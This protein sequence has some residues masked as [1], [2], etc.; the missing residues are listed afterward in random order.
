MDL[1]QMRQEILD[2]HEQIKGT[3]DY[4]RKYEALRYI[5]ALTARY[6]ASIYHIDGLY[7]YR[8][9]EK[10]ADNMLL[11]SGKNLAQADSFRRREQEWRAS[12]ALNSIALDFFIFQLKAE[13][14]LALSGKYL[15]ELSGELPKSPI[16]RKTELM[17]KKILRHHDRSEGFD[18]TPYVEEVHKNFDLQQ[19]FA[20]QPEYATHHG[21]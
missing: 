7:N 18:F 15:P 12:I 4:D 8:G 1:M 20:E 11:I 16:Y 13:R 6:V 3:E 14:I 10:M 17:W 2:Y 19:D 21:D 9:L 5:G